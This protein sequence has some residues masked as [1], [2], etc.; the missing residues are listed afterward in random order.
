VKKSVIALILLAVLIIIVSPGIIGKLAE[1]SVTENLNWAA[2]ESGELIVTSDGFDRGWFSSEGQHRVEIGDG[3]IRAAMSSANDGTDDTEIPALLINTRIDHGL[4]P[5]SSMS[6]EEGSLSPGLGSAV[7]TLAFEMAD[8]ESIDLPGTIYSDLSLGGN[9]N[10]RYVLDA[11]S[12]TADDGEVT[13]QP[14]TI[15]VAANAK[16]GDITFEGDVGAMTFAND[17]DIVSID[18]LTIV[19]SQVNTPYGFHVGDLDLNMGT[20]TINSNGMATGGMQG[21][22]VKGSSSI[23]DGLVTAAMRLEMSDQTVPSFGDISVI[24]DMAFDDVDA[25]ALGAVSRRL[26]EL[27]GSQNPTMVMMTAEE[28]LKDLAAAGINITIDQLDVALPMGTVTSRMSFELPKSDRAAFAW[29]SLL[30][31][32]VGEVYISVPEA[33]VQLATSMDPQAG[34]L[35]GMGYLKKEGSVYVLDAQMK[36]G[37]L[38]VNGAPIPIPMGAFQ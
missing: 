7:S 23:D 19:G 16:T 25:V 22:S 31:D 14:S 21:M 32:L 29:T 24:A 6:R 1:D 15:R 35:V 12:H 27:S 11:G 9:L 3:S 4:I 18:S 13:W 8:G 5:L 37:L 28:E 20:M 17:L 38:T 26:E 30:L 2:E 34:A 33:L 36:K 10:S